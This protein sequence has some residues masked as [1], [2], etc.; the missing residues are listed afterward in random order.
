MN[1]YGEYIATDV[2]NDNYYVYGLNGKADGSDGVLTYGDVFE[3][4][5]EI[6][7]AKTKNANDGTVKFDENMNRIGA[8]NYGKHFIIY[9]ISN[10]ESERSVYDELRAWLASLDIA[11]AEIDN[12]CLFIYIG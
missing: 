12:I 3:K 7:Y 1:R 4:F 2:V 5:R 9:A 8:V 10:V 11:Q 6:A